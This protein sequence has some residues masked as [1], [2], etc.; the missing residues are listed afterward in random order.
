[1]SSALD[2]FLTGRTRL[3][4][5][6]MTQQAEVDLEKLLFCAKAEGLS[7]QHLQ[8]LMVHS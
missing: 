5:I 6:D 4:P 1:M 8:L 3:H 2:R 7:T